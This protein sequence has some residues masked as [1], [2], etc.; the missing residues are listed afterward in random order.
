MTNK[1]E[2][3]FRYI[4]CADFWTEQDADAMFDFAKGIPRVREDSEYMGKINGKRRIIGLGSYSISPNK[5]GL[6]D[7]VVNPKSQ[8]IND[9]PPIVRALAE[10]L[11]KFNDGREINYLSFIAYENEVDHIGW[12]QH[13]EDRCRD[14]TVY[15][16]SLGETR[17]FGLRRVCEKHRIGGCKKNCG[18]LCLPDRKQLC[19]ECKEKRSQQGGCPTGCKKKHI[20]FN[21]CPDCETSPNQW[22]ALQPDHGSVIVLPDSYNSTHEHSILGKQDKGGD[23]RPKGLRISIN[24]K[25]IRPEDVLYIEREN[26]SAM[27]HGDGEPEAFPVGMIPPDSS[28]FMQ[29]KGTRGTGAGMRV[30]AP[31]NGKPRVWCCRAGKQY[32]PDAIYVGCLTAR[33][34]GTI[35]GNDHEP[36]KGHKKW[37]AVNEAA[38]RK[39]A[40]QK[41]RD[42][43]FKAQAIKDLRGKHLLCWCSQ[44]KNPDGSCK[45]PFC[46]ARVWLEIVNKPKG[47]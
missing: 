27:S 41:M 16:V 24:T 22:T 29:G 44:D 9:A 20:H 2:Q 36:F 42:A 18:E 43:A 23:K 30:V 15:I 1:Q 46:H 47:K 26:R 10:R 14:A 38:F 5:R 12:H 39:Y 40:K 45:Q 33:F 11:T 8:D 37:I 6:R 32:P 19:R 25:Q 17:T 34:P 28:A 21:P 35:Y 4:P 3:E 7:G 31:S 13:N